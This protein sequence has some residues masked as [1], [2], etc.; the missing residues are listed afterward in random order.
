[1]TPNCPVCG[2][3]MRKGDLRR[4]IF[5]CPGCKATLRFEE[6]HETGLV[7]VGSGLLALIVTYKGGAQGYA[8]LLYAAPLSLVFACAAGALRGFLFPRKLKRVISADDDGRIL[9]IT[10]PSDSAK[11]E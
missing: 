8:F 11:N 3:Q 10:G 9:H 5:A 7:M 4:G 6:G 2:W 1:M